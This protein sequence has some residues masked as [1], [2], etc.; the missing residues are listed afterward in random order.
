MV[1]A[2][3]HGRRMNINDEPDF[4][5]TDLRTGLP[6]DRVYARQQWR[7]QR[8]RQLSVAVT[9]LVLICALLLAFVGVPGFG[10]NVRQALRKTAPT[11]SLV[12]AIG[13]DI[14]YFEHGLPW[15]T[16]LLDGRAVTNVDSEQPY[17]GFEQL[18][19]S[20]HIPQGRHLLT[21]T[22]SPFP[23]LRCWISTPAATSDTCPL[24]RDRGV[25]DVAPPFPAERVLNLGGDP[26]SLS[27]TLQAALVT[28][29]AQ[30]IATLSASTTLASGDTF[31]G[32][33]GVPRLASS[34]MAATLT[35]AV[36]TD[37]TSSY[38]IPGSAHGCAILCAIQPAS[39]VND[40]QAQWV[41]AVHVLPAWTYTSTSGVVVHGRAAQPGVLSDSVVPLSVHWN[42]G[43]QVRIA[44]SLATSPI[45]FIALNLFAALHLAGAPL[46]S[47]KMVSAPKAADGC[48][49]AGD[50][51][52]ATGVPR[53]PFTLM[54]RFG[55]LYAVDAEA[56][57][58]LP[59]MR[60]A[61]ARLQSLARAWQIAAGF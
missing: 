57:L 26:G 24:I 42:N 2:A 18:Y 20:L 50:A 11:P 28:A 16:L 30:T 44:D 6:D 59:A 34:P 54:Y 48:L 25:Q 52:D 9:G 45:C 43:W 12:G 27:P 46:S 47:L 51:V 10:A 13:G 33:D 61:D 53:I 3:N 56:H 17:T 40:A 60:V 22:A 19:T 29:A 32:A 31:A 5:V 35:Y 1:T 23:T 21:Y 38:I 36:A 58:L 41:V 37:P 49:A 55:L 14:I 7:G 15:G 4:E 8:R 39:Y